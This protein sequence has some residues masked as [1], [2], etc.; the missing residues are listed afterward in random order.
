ML[1]CFSSAGLLET[2]SNPQFD[3]ESVNQYQI[4][5]TAEN[6][7]YESTQETLTIRIQDVNEMPLFTTYEYNITI[8][9]G[10]V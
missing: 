2:S 9:E 1:T 7:L 5:M 6:Y 4:V 10:L 3:Y 8:N